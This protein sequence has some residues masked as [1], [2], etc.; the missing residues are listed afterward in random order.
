MPPCWTTK[1]REANC[2]GD[3]AQVPQ[4]REP[5]F[6]VVAIDS[7]CESFCVHLSADQ[8]TRISHLEMRRIAVL[9]V[10]AGLAVA[11]SG[12]GDG[13]QPKREVLRSANLISADLYVRV[14][15]PSGVVDHIV[16]RLR[17][18]AFDTYGR[19]PFL[20]PRIRHHR[21][22]K[23]CS[24]THTIGDADS[25]DVQAWR[26]KKVRVDVY[27]DNKSSESIFCQILPLIL[28]QGS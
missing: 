10:V 15:G 22:Q 27:G 26:G 20:P 25:P 9:L 21:R 14:S 17:A 19:G 24:I 1:H 28:A 3:L 16:D 12:C 5:F 8:R 4:S 11:V 23:V 2:L 7:E 6:A 18:S 13:S